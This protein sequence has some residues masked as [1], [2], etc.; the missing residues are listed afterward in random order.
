[1]TTHDPAAALTKALDDPILKALADPTRCALVRTLVRL[2]SA[3]IATI[4]DAHPQDRSVISRHLAVLRDA[5]VV[6][7]S[8]D[9]RHVRYALDGPA[10]VSKLEDI[11]AAARALTAICCPSDRAG[12]VG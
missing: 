9:G 3:D 4:S 11:L 10:L 7:S 2:G 6:R 8:K 12:P 1:M 5:G